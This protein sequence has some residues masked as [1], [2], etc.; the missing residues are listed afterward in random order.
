MITYHI[1]ISI[2]IFFSEKSKFIS[3]RKCFPVKSG[4]IPLPRFGCSFLVAMLLRYA[5]AKDC[6]ER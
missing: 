3:A 5:S 4:D 1:L 6:G 2:C